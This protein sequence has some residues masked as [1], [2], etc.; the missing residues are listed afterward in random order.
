MWQELRSGQAHEEAVRT[1][2]VPRK[3]FIEAAVQITVA[4]VSMSLDDVLVVAGSAREHPLVLV[5]G[6][7]LTIALMGAPPTSSRGCWS[8]IVGSRT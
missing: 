8:N 1:E 6:L 5:I 2:G 7:L 3:T 4:D